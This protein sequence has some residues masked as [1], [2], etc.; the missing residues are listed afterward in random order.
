[1]INRGTKGIKWARDIYEI[2]AD[3]PAVAALI[4]LA[5]T[6]AAWVVVRLGL[7][8]WVLRRRDMITLLDTEEIVGAPR[9]HSATLLKVMHL[10]VGGREQRDTIGR[11]IG[12][13]KR[14]EKCL[15]LSHGPPLRARRRQGNRGRGRRPTPD[16][17]GPCR[18]A[19]ATGR[20]R[21]RA[22]EEAFVR[23]AAHGAGKTTAARG[24]ERPV[25]GIINRGGGTSDHCKKTRNDA[26]VAWNPAGG[27]VGASAGNTSSRRGRRG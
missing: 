15:R 14:R 5:G 9:W 26:P 6:R 21:P 8:R 27:D 18:L 19:A 13:T 7:R 25:S 24:A 17:L 23:T 1:M 16:D 4:E 22:D 10:S 12:T 20:E 2:A 11:S 3:V